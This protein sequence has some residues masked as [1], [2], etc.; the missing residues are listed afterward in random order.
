MSK[1]LNKQIGKRVQTARKKSN[2]TQE[3]LAEKAKLS[4]QFLS[5][6]ETGRSGMS[7]ETLLSL[8][9]ILNVTPNYILGKNNKKNISPEIEELLVDFPI[10]LIPYVEN[11]L[12]SMVEVHKNEKINS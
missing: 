4:P 2:L 1:Y 10:N 9:D 11:I 3:K 6:I 5:D 8:C 12:K 7:F